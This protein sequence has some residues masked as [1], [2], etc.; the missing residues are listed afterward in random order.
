MDR[1]QA[2]DHYNILY[3]NARAG[4]KEK[5]VVQSTIDNK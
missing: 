1:R 5:K 2:A 3:W 4:M